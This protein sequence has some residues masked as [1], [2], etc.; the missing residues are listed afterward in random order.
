M[1][2]TLHEPN[3]DIVRLTVPA[4]GAY[5]STLRL[6]AAGLAARCDLTVDDIAVPGVPGSIAG[7]LLVGMTALRA[8]PYVREAPPGVVTAP[9]F[10]A[11]RG[12]RGSG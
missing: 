2:E 12:P 11:V 4:T 5:I 1:T 8:L 7:H 9:V 6:T 3:G 10:G